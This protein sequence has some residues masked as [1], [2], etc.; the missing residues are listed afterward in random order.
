MRWI[1]KDFHIHHCRQAAQA[2]STNAK[3]VHFVE[4]LQTQF[5]NSVARPFFLQVLNINRVHEGSLRHQHGFFC[6]SSNANT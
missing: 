1:I 5:L 6:R 2:L 3:R 4:D